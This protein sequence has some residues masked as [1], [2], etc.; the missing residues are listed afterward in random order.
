V[1]SPILSIFL[2][3]IFLLLN[4]LDAHSTWL[5]VSPNHYYRE[6]NIFARYFFKRLGIVAGIVTFKIILLS[7]LGLLIWF[8]V[9]PEYLSLNI[10]ILIGNAIFTI[11]VLNNYRIYRR[12]SK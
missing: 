2:L 12:I 11:V 9:L 4:V 6:K 7:I 8:Y 3:L 5:V 10:S 1:S